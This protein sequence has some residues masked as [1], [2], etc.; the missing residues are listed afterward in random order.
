M[1]PFSQKGA[2][3]TGGS[4]EPLSEIRIKLNMKSISDTG[5]VS[6]HLFVF[7]ALYVSVSIVARTKSNR[8]HKT[9]NL[10]KNVA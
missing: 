4:D 8:N 10:H 7:T 9:E 5:I 3:D 6:L 2:V 1:S